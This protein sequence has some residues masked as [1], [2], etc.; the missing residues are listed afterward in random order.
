MAKTRSQVDFG[1]S[2]PLVWQ[3][4]VEGRYA[5]KKLLADRYQ[6]METQTP[7]QFIVI[8]YVSVDRFGHET[9][10]KTKAGDIRR[11]E[12]LAQAEDFCLGREA[13]PEP[14]VSQPSKKAPST[15]REPKRSPARAFHELLLAGATDE[16]AY[17]KVVAE[18]GET[19]YRPTY[20]AW[21][22]KQLV[23]KGLL[24]A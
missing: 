12:T 7:G 17:S 22:R 2:S 6:I 4:P 8:D 24:S 18:F 11:F 10:I 1:P 23:K 16:D 20:P 13:S 19:S 15:P 21:Y 14:T 5:S 3:K 9:I